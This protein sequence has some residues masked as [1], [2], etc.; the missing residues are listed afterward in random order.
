MVQTVSP[1]GTVQ[2]L[3]DQ[4]DNDDFLDLPVP[5]THVSQLRTLSYRDQSK[6]T[7]PIP[8]AVCYIAKRTSKL[9]YPGAKNCP[10]NWTKEVQGALATPNTECFA[11][12]I[13]IGERF[14][15]QVDWSRNGYSRN[16]LNLVGPPCGDKSSCETGQIPCTVCSR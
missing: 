15:S 13:C 3:Q 14:L 6:G 5:A 11:D 12:T 7:Q 2:C 10:E 16:D 8:C 1:G 9:T 4:L